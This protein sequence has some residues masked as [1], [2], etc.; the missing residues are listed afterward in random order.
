MGGLLA[1]GAYVVLKGLEA[2]VVRAL[3]LQGAAH[4]IDGANPI[5]A[6]NLFFFALLMLGL[7]SVAIDRRG[8]HRQLPRLSAVQRRWLG[9]DMLAGSLVGPFGSYVAIEALAV[10]EKT[11]LFSLVLPASA[12]LSLLWLGEPLPRRFWLTTGLIVTGLAVASLAS[13]APMASGRLAGL[14]WGLVGVAGFSCSA[15][16]ARRLGREGLGLG[17]TTG[18]P[19]LVAALVFLVIGLVLYGPEH[20][21]HLRLWWVA[22]VIGLYAVTLVLG[23]EWSLRLCYQH[24]SVA[25]VAIVGSLTIAVA[26]ISAAALLG[27]PVGPPVLLGTAVVVVGVMLAGG[28]RVRPSV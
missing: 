27:E 26:V 10:I 19:S 1:L 21:M 22:G 23:S 6:C 11:L 18:L 8:L 13:G 17:L 15:V 12:L 3:Q 2:T 25:R 5:S 24:F 28:G 7:S 16:T 9:L 20:F 14:G 4:P